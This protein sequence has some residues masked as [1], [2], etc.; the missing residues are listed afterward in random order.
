VSV[1]GAR[2]FMQEPTRLMIRKFDR[3]MGSDIFFDNW[4]FA[5]TQVGLLRERPIVRRSGGTVADG[6]AGIISDLMDHEIYT[7]ILPSFQKMS[8]I[9]MAIGKNVLG[10]GQPT[11]DLTG[12]QL[13]YFQR[14][15][16]FLF[17]KQ[18]FAAR[19]LSVECRFNPYVVPGFPGAMIDAP[20]NAIETNNNQVILGVAEQ[21][22]DKIVQEQGLSTTAAEEAVRAQRGEILDLLKGRTGVHWMGMVEAVT[23]SLVANG[24]GST[25]ITLSYARDHREKVEYFGEDIVENRRR[26]KIYREI[27]R[28]MTTQERVVINAAIEAANNAETI[29]VEAQRSALLSSGQASLDSDFTAASASMASATAVGQL[30]QLADSAAERLASL[31]R[32]GTIADRELIT[33]KKWTVACLASSLPQVGAVGPWGGPIKEARD[34]TDQFASRAAATPP[35]QQEIRAI[36]EQLQ[37]LDEQRTRINQEL[38]ARALWMP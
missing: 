20:T 21:E 16:N 19:T 4:Y 11:D 3:L 17:F 24:A 1:S 14:V 33:T 6:D 38:Q 10:A 37:S 30:A 2:N 34:I 31:I 8:D 7:G 26:R 5:P 9:E 22:F 13:D 23:H 15:T 12:D 18:R 28:R 29:A 27:R 25:R 35:D 36:D 32:V